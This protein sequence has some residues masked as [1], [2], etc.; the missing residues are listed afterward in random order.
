MS[1]T[2]SVLSAILKPLTAMNV[3]LL[4]WGRQISWV[5]VTVMIAAIALQ[6]FF[7]YV[8]ND[9]LPWP[10]EL[11]RVMMIYIMAL[12]TPSAYRWGGFVSIKMLMDALPVQVGR[13][14]HLILMMGLA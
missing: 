13:L 7:R 14:L 2:L 12:M 10:E 5:L 9:A 6:I 11:A 4:W 8:L 1:P 3:S